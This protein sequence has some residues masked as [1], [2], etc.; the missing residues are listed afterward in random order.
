MKRIIFVCML[1]ISAITFSQGTGPSITLHN[2][3]ANCQVEYELY[4]INTTTLDCTSLI[5]STHAL[6]VLTYGYVVNPF[7]GHAFVKVKVQKGGGTP[8]CFIAIVEPNDSPCNSVAIPEFVHF[9]QCC[10]S[11]IS[12]GMS[13][14]WTGGMASPNIV[15]QND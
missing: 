1:L 14:K 2:D 8:S 10:S 12:G 7:P 5:V 11:S 13:V 6:G 15:T 4:Q 3:L 9:D